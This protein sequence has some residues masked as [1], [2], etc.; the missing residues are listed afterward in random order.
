MFDPNELSQAQRE[1]VER[2]DEEDLQTVIGVVGTHFL[3]RL[4]DLDD[5][6]PDWAANFLQFSASLHRR[7]VLDP[8][9]KALCAVGQNVIL[10]NETGVRLHANHALEAGATEEEVGE[11]ILQTCFFN[12]FP[13]AHR[14]LRVFRELVA[15]R[16][17]KS[18][19]DQSGH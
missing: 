4:A 17:E 10:N 3:G 14:A 18:V 9:T 7:T 15:E 12:G 11:V 19:G 13:A 16:G 8:K 6:D 5:F 2:Y 1:L